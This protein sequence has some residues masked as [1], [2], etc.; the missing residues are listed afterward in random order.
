MKFSF[1]TLKTI[2]KR[3]SHSASHDLFNSR[4]DWKY[5]LLC[6]GSLAIALGVL[7]GYLFFKI[8]RGELFLPQPRTDEQSVLVNETVVHDTVRRFEEKRA[9]FEDTQKSSVSSADPAL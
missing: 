9:L 1:N 7:S 6:A 3:H 2:F 8:N 5:I 4:R